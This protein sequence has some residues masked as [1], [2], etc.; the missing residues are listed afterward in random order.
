[1]TKLS[2]DFISVFG[3]PPVEFIQLAAALGCQHISGI[4]EP[5]DYNPQGYRKYSLRNDAVLRR[6]LK[7]A[8][9]DT[10]VTVALAE[11]F[12]IFPGQD[13]RGLQGDLEIMRDL[14]ATK[15]NL[16]AF[17]PDGA[18]CLDQLAVLAEMV[19]KLGMETLVEYAPVFTIPD[20]PAALAAIRHVDRKDCKIL[21]DTMH[22]G[23]TGASGADLAA[24][25]PEVIGYIQL[26]DAPLVPTNESYMDEAMYERL[27][28]GSG[29]MPLREMLAA[30]PLD[31]IIGLEV[32]QRSLADAGIGPEERM[33]KCVDGARALLEQVSG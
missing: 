31:R 2:L 12:S 10:G 15:I 18:R 33:R 26:C 17:E 19:G 30:L 14:G 27:P 5:I 22:T 4:M 24:L 32:P 29:E 21:V 20:L 23:R 9:R 6:D 7:A 1:M 8:M 25:D 28:P 16:A 13:V 3:L 11:G